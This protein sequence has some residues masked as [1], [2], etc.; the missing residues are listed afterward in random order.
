M[1]LKSKTQTR[2]ST[3][4]YFII[5]KVIDVNIGTVANVKKASKD[6]LIE[7]FNAK[8]V[9]SLMKL[10]CMHDIEIEASI[11]VSKNS[12]RGVASHRDFVDMTEDEIVDNM[13]D[14]GVIGARNITKFVDGARRNT[15]SGTL[16]FAVV[17]LSVEWM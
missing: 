16:T 6:L 13:H 8:Q 11:P 15:A 14:Q 7:T 9:S 5:K 1:T 3:V 12:C 4:N 2:L 17:K 10:R